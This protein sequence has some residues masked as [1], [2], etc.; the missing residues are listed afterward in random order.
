LL[1][2][3]L[4]CDGFSP[5]ILDAMI[6]TA[7][8]VQ[9]VA[10]ENAQIAELLKSGN[11]FLASGQWNFCESRIGNAGFT[12]RAQK[13]QLQPNETARTN[14]ANKK[15]DAQ[16]KTSDRAQAALAKYEK[17]AGSLT[18]KEWGKIV[19]WVL[20]VAKV[21]YLLK[22]LKKQEQILAKLESLPNTWTSH[23]PS[24]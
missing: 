16:L 18:E 2:E 10:T 15:N 8:H 1:V 23:L 11:A 12:L 19:R 3:D 5:G 9:R 4:E 14:S 13:Q 17:D 20:P 24:L 7:A 22:D 6:P 21:P